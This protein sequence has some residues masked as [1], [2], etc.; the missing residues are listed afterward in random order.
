MYNNNNNNVKYRQVTIDNDKFDLLFVNYST[1]EKSVM[2]NVA[3]GWSN[4]DDNLI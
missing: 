1:I 4:V 2:H 3:I